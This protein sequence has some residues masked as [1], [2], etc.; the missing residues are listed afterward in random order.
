MKNIN[1]YCNWKMQLNIDSSISLFRSMIN[2]DIPL[3]P[4]V[5]VMVFPS[6]FALHPLNN[7]LS[8]T[9]VNKPNTG[10]YLI[11]SQNV[12][13][14]LSGAF[15]GESSILMLKDFC[16]AVIVGH[17]ERRINNHETN[18]QINS[19]VKL[20]TKYNLEAVICIG[21]QKNMADGD[22]ILETQITS[23]L[24]G[25]NNNAKITL[26]YEPIWAIGSG[27]PATFEIANNKAATIRSIIGRNFSDRI[28]PIKILYGGSVDLANVKSYLVS[29][30]LDGVL[31]GSASLKSESINGIISTANSIG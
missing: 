26:A 16:S 23:A 12:H 11:G 27:S 3:S 6:E 1:I 29:S 15:T 31:I 17:S 7:M 25:V 5:N 20:I 19:K 30:D 8:D 9:H 28:E 10:R 22:S 21:E 18:A 2:Y 13:H 14:E 4:Q 24:N